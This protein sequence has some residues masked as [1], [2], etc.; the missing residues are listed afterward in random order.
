MKQL[1]ERGPAWCIESVLSTA[2]FEVTVSPYNKLDTNRFGLS[3][4]VQVALTQYPNQG[5]TVLLLGL[6]FRI[7][8]HIVAS[9][10]ESTTGGSY[11]GLVATAGAPPQGVYSCSHRGLGALLATCNRQHTGCSCGS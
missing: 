7:L 5:W 4:L 3:P 1:C 6:P 9:V 2:V 11:T 8:E 10:Q